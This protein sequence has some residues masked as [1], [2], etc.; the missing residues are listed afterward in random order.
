MIRLIAETAWHH[1]GDF[2]FMKNLVSKIVS[3]TTADIVKMHITINF[4]EYMDPSHRSYEELKS[5]IFSRDQWKELIRI[6]RKG[7]KEIMLLLN[8]IQAIEF[9]LSFNPEYVEIH[10][11][12]LNDIFMLKKLKNSIKKKT[13]IV[14][15]VGG[16]SLDEIKNVIN[17][18]KRPNIILMFGF[19]NYPTI[20]EN[21]NLDKIKRLMRLFNNFEYGYADHTAWDSD[22]NE[23]ITLL[24]AATGMQYLEK[25]VTT[26]YGKKRLDWSSA[27]SIKMLNSLKDKAKILE[28]LNGNGSLYMTS[29]EKSYSVFGPMKKA[30]MLISDIP[31]GS[32][33]RLKDIKF[34][35]TKEI[36]DMSQ[37]DV[38]NSIGK[39]I[40]NNLKK[41]SILMSKYF[42]RNK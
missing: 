28:K 10:S 14:L 24:G 9:G 27:I 26:H 42:I 19:Q 31:K 11:V 23:L 7:K 4:D 35:R 21:V 8:D 15:G 20:Y 16:T 3:E 36:S 1:E 13:K 39:K 6:I 17:F 12:C 38:I 37:L 40:S 2:P 22:H 33:L 18:L 34:I 25:H 29:G 30:A 5:M 41:G 32:I